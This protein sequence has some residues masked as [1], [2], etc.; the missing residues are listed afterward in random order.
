MLTFDYYVLNSY[1]PEAEGEGPDLYRKWREQVVL[2]D[3]LGFT[4]AWFTEHHFHPFGGMLPN[5]R[6][7]IAA[8]AQHTSR[9]RFGTAVIVLPFYNPVRVAEDVAMLDILSNGRLEVGI[10]RGM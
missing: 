9:I 7:L 10:G 4:C 1:V 8:L 3:E 5:P 2:A 6:L